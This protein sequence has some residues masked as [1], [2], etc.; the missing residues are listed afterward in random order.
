MRT[1][2]Y[3]E[4]RTQGDLHA[5]IEAALEAW[6]HCREHDPQADLI[7]ATEV[8]DRVEGDWLEGS[9]CPA[10]IP[11]PEQG[12]EGDLRERLRALLLAA[13]LPASQALE[14]LWGAPTPRIGAASF[15]VVESSHLGTGA[16]R[17]V[18]L[19]WGDQ[20]TPR[21]APPEHGD[22]RAEVD[23]AV[24]QT[25]RLL[26]A[27]LPDGAG[28]WIWP[29]VPGNRDLEDGS[30]GFAAAVATASWLLRRPTPVDLAFTGFVGAPTPERFEGTLAAKA[31]IVARH[32]YIRR[33]V[34]PIECSDTPLD[35]LRRVSVRG[36]NELLEQ[37]FG[38]LTVR[39]YQSVR[40]SEHQ[41][42]RGELSE[43]ENRALALLACA[44]DPL[45]LGELAEGILCVDVW[46]ISLDSTP[47]T[48]QVM[49]RLIELRLVRDV[50]ERFVGEQTPELR[51]LS[52]GLWPARAHR[53]MA[54]T[55][56]EGQHL[57][58][59][60]HLLALGETLQ[61]AACLQP[62]LATSVGLE[63]TTR[64]LERLSRHHTRQQLD[65]LLSALPVDEQVWCLRLGW[66]ARQTGW[67]L[68]SIAT[69]LFQQSSPQD[70]LMSLQGLV[71]ST[72]H[73]LVACVRGLGAVSERHLE[74]LHQRPSLGLMCRILE[75]FSQV[76]EP[77][78]HPVGAVL[79]KHL[80]P[81]FS[82]SGRSDSIGAMFNRYL[83]GPGGFAGALSVPGVAEACIERLG[84]TLD[85]LLRA[86]REILGDLQLRRVEHRPIIAPAESGEAD[87]DLSQSLSGGEEDSRLFWRRG[88]VQ[89]RERFW[90][91]YGLEQIPEPQRFSSGAP[92][93]DLLPQP[94][95]R[96]IA[97]AGQN[98]ERDGKR[99]AALEAAFGAALRLAWFSS[100][101]PWLAGAGWRLR[102]RQA[103][104][105]RRMNLRN[106]LAGLA[107]MRDRGTL[108]PPG[109][110][111]MQREPILW[112]LV[113]DLE[114]LQHAPGPI[115]RWRSNLDRIEANLHALLEGLPWCNGEVLLIAREDGKQWRCNG[116]TAARESS[117]D[118][119]NVG[120]AFVGAGGC[121]PLEPLACFAGGEVLLLR[122]LNS[123]SKELG[124]SAA[125]LT[126]VER[127]RA[128]PALYRGEWM[129]GA[130]PMLRVGERCP[131]HP[132]LSEEL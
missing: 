9:L 80:R 118:A 50:G 107:G 87:I 12:W 109:E 41:A 47:V 7:W 4:L 20:Y 33:L 103:H 110:L 61:A 63:V 69:Q 10:P 45:S 11:H 59:C 75:E 132:V 122:Q 28:W 22:F 56:P 55:L 44:L 6:E 36:L 1:Q 81:V 99:A 23:R 114:R 116:F 78:D 90:C 129:P 73:L 113:S 82:G 120:L 46:E 71:E 3:S 111:L 83:H 97:T 51:H 74:T 53:A 96:A 79:F 35:R 37:V 119:G 27:S 38:A 108:L 128:N 8:L 115:A 68:A 54:L 89:D 48:R 77:P 62:I 124:G 19:G 39:D 126:A 100:L 57:R 76:E 58:R 70:R 67:P 24:R 25:C 64:G 98:R 60:H 2:D 66:M 49:D 93:P 16:L 32:G 34:I 18:R 5:L 84:P 104:Y 21:Y 127:G 85:P 105:L 130:P 14:R 40:R 86:V 101:S 31:R 123:S 29:D 112:A 72:L 52:G 131:R 125:L 17:Q 88:L 43:V 94:I 15:P 30:A 65:A 106:L 102:G 92:R 13:R 95:A 117:V 121:W 91:L 42:R 26:G